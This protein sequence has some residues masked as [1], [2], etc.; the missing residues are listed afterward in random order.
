[1]LSFE[2]SDFMWAKG[3]TEP[4]SGVLHDSEGDVVDLT[5]LDLYMLIEQDSTA[6]SVACSYDHDISVPSRACPAPD[7]TYPNDD[8]IFGDALFDF[9]AVLLPGAYVYFQKTGEIKIHSRQ[10][11]YV[12]EHYV[13]L[14]IELPD[15]LDATWSWWASDDSPTLAKR[16]KFKFTPSIASMDN[17]PFELQAKL[18][19]GSTIDF[20]LHLT[21]RVITPIQP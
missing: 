13:T 14:F 20:S 11:H 8:L 5:G 21:G 16:G 19:Y 6:V 15:Q 17:G 12:N 2:L 4:V 1:M 18:D 9:P 3:R 10:L 7:V